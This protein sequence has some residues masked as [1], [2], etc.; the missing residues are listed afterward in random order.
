MDYNVQY[1]PTKNRIRIASCEST[2]RFQGSRRNSSF[3]EKDKNPSPN[4][5]ERLR[6]TYTLTAPFLN[7]H[8]G[9]TPTAA[10]RRCGAWT[11]R[12]K[13]LGTSVCRLGGN[14]WSKPGQG[15]GMHRASDAE[16]SNERLCHRLKAPIRGTVTC[17]SY[18]RNC[19]NWMS[20]LRLSHK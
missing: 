15:C 18:Q 7:P 5:T 1:Q 20:V 9:S 12:D 8:R 2:S 10:V 19:V 3:W 16:V 14:P 13:A 4:D 6:T 11:R 17:L